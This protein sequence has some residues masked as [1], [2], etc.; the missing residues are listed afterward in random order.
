MARFYL[1]PE[2][3]SENPRLEGDEARHLSQVLRKKIGDRIFVFDGVGRSAE[4]KVLTISRNHVDLSIG[5]EFQT[6]KTGPLIT[7]A[8]AIP[9]GKNMDLIVQKSVELG[10]HR[11]QPLVT[12]YTVTQPG[13][14]KSDKWRRNALEACKQCGQ[15]VLP[16]IDEPANFGQWI[17]NAA[18]GADLKIIASLLP[19]AQP[20]RHVLKDHPRVKAITLLVGPEGDFSIEESQKA[21]ERGFLPISLGSQILRV[22]TATLFCL[23]VLHYVYESE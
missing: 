21:I 18:E 7:L 23:S 3:W 11:I 22:E 20:M 10:V 12:R 2:S 8:Q 16:I 9:K 13:D 4:A 15:D 1:P 17:Q 6:D 5:P 14:G 19:N